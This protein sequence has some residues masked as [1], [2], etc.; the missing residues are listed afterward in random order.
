MSALKLYGFEKTRPDHPSPSGF[1]QKVETFLRVTGTPYEDIKTVP[2]FAPKGKL[3][4]ITHNGNTVPDSSFIIDYLVSSGTSRDPNAPLTSRQKAESRAWQ[5][6]IEEVL[7]DS[8]VWT[9]WM[10]PKDY[11]VSVQEN[12]GTLPWFIRPL[13]A[14]YF[15]RFIGNV[16][17]TKGMGR[18]KPAEIEEIM[19]RAWKDVG[20]LVGDGTQ[21]I[22]GTDEPA[23]MDIVVY[24]FCVHCLSVD[25]NPRTDE[26]ILENN[27]L[28]GYLNRI[29]HNF[30]PEYKRILEK[31]D[32]PKKLQ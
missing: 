22:F 27:A 32:K 1:C 3:P 7:Y 10:D 25:G 31:L 17:W 23:I 6:Y 28:V 12:M 15:R 29:T 4:Y 20:K 24:S 30:F 18:H 2:F 13:A 8:I 26:L 16:M 11:P 19:I 21:Y 5:A 14:V 9:R